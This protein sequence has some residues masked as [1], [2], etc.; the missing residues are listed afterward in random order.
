MVS[1]KH[2][3]TVTV[4]M[5]VAAVVLGE[6]VPLV[7]LGLCLYIFLSLER[8]KA[9]PWAKGLLL[10]VVTWYHEGGPFQ[11][12]CSPAI[13][14]DCLRFAQIHCLVQPNVPREDPLPQYRGE[15]ISSLRRKQQSVPTVLASRAPP[16]RPC[17]QELPVFTE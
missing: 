10:G 1:V 13:S 4:A 5:V 2:I 7:G 3:L 8:C 14:P 15:V 17:S 9:A 12:G 11:V 16:G 6:M